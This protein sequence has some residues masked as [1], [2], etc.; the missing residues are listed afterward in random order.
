VTAVNIPQPSTFFLLALDLYYQI[1]QEVLFL[2]AAHGPACPPSPHPNQ[3]SAPS[4][5]LR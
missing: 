1:L 5:P 2:A 4:A 3:I